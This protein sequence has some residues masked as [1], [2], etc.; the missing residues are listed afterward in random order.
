MVMELPV[1]LATFR[2]ILVGAA[3]RLFVM[4]THAVHAVVRV[5]DEDCRRVEGRETLTSM[6][7]V[8]SVERLGHVLGL[9]DSKA[10]GPRDP[11]HRR[12][13][14]ILRAGDGEAAVEV[15]A[16]LGEQEVLIKGL[17]PSFKR[18]ATFGGRRFW[19]P[20]WWSPF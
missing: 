11:D 19:A 17:G 15:D 10:Q 4:P 3:G 2:G 13:A 1:S 18:Y 9:A 8:I 12:T 16:V 20:D 7:R 14:L 5:R 6:E